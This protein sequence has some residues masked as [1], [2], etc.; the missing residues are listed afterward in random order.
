MS[1]KEEIAMLHEKVA[2]M[3]GDIRT[4]VSVFIGVTKA[5][6]LNLSDL[7]GGGTSDIMAKLPQILTK[8][9]MKLTTGGFDT[10][11]FSEMKSLAPIMEEYKHLVEDIIQE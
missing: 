1:E 3:E 10:S 5:L 7:Q 8:V 4:T 9:M 6:D 2:K 11:L